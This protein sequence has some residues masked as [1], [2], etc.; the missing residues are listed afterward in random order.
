VL[1]IARNTRP[2]LLGLLPNETKERELSAFDWSLLPLLSEDGRTLVFTDAGVAAGPGY[3]VYLRKLDGSPAVRLGE[4]SALA[5][6]PD[7][8]WVLTCLMRSTPAPIV[9]LPT[10]VGEARTFPADSIDHA[11]F[12]ELAAF[13]P[14]G[15]SIVFVGHEP[16]KPARVFVQ[17]LAGGAARAVTPEGVT[18]SLLSPDGKSLLIRTP[19][20]GFTLATLDA[21]ASRVVPG[22]DPEDRPLRWTSDGQGLFVGHDERDRPARVFLV[23]VGTGRR[24]LWKEFTPADPAGMTDVTPFAIS[25]DGKTIIFAYVRALSELYLANGLH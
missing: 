23:H 13:L 17:D 9:L 6:S 10:G 24:Q 21:G 7:G 4:G 5:V 16:G 25:A 14:D 12:E 15:K 2:G 3:S 11:H 1:Y 19:D 8:K 18:A 20:K 22:L